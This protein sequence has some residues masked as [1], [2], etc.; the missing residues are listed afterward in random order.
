MLVNVMQ[1]VIVGQFYYWT[2]SAAVSPSSPLRPVGLYVLIISWLL[3]AFSGSRA[4]SD[5]L[6]RKIL[7]LALTVALA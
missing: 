2:Q 4:G 3:I 6:H 5:L 7:R 1:L